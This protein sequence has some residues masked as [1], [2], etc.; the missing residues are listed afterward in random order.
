SNLLENYQT[1]QKNLQKTL[2]N[3]KAKNEKVLQIEK[4]KLVEASKSNLD[5]KKNAYQKIVEKENEILESY[6]I[7]CEPYQKSVKSL[8]SKNKKAIEKKKLDILVKK[9]N[10]KK[11][12]VENLLKNSDNPPTDYP[13]DLS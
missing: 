12:Y 11:Q 13:S 7:K 6:K 8:R 3:L 4:M 5:L 9:S 10:M 2:D 1:R